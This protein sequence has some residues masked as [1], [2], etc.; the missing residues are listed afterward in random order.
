MLDQ[1]CP[2]RQGFSLPKSYRAEVKFLE[3]PTI[4]WIRNQHVGFK[5]LGPAGLR[6][7]TVLNFNQ[8]PPYVSRLLKRNKRIVSSTL[9]DLDRFNRGEVPAG[10][11]LFNPIFF[12]RDERIGRENPSDGSG[13]GSG[14]FDQIF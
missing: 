12:R 8:I 6:M 13:S 7:F 1:P 4:L 3:N 2:Q 10:Q 11:S 9:K 14:R 5:G